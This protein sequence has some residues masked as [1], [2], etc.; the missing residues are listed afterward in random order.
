[1]QVHIQF[2]LIIDILGIMII[3]CN[4]VNILYMYNEN[5]E[6]EVCSPRLNDSILL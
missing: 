5:E 2:S 3:L 6:K 1:M 4:I